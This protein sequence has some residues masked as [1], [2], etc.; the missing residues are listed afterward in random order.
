MRKSY[1]ATG[2]WHSGE[3]ILQKIRTV[4]KKSTV[5]FYYIDFSFCRCGY[6]VNIVGVYYISHLSP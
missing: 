5:H 3:A 2:K 4:L 6:V 1:P